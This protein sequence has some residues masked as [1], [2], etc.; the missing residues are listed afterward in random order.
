MTDTSLLI[1]HIDHSSCRQRSIIFQIKINTERKSCY[2][3]KFANKMLPHPLRDH[4]IRPVSIVL[5]RYSY[6]TD[7]YI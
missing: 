1:D 5:V 7:I 2:V 4:F 3:V 6:T